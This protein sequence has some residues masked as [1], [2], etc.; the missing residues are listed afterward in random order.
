M[1]VEEPVAPFPYCASALG[2]MARRLVFDGATVRL[3]EAPQQAM[4]LK[5]VNLVFM[6]GKPGMDDVQPADRRLGNE[7]PDVSVV[8]V[9]ANH[10]LDAPTINSPKDCYSDHASDDYVQ[11]ACL[12]MFDKILHWSTRQLGNG[13]VWTILTAR[14]SIAAGDGG[15]GHTIDTNTDLKNK[16]VRM[17]GAIAKRYAGWDN[18]LGYEVMSEPRS[19]TH[20]PELSAARQAACSAIWASDPRAAC[21]VGPA[22]FYNRCNLDNLVLVRGGPAVYLA[23]FFEP[24][25][26][27]KN[28]FQGDGYPGTYDCCTVT[29]PCQKREVCGQYS[30]QCPGA[31]RVRID[32]N[33]VSAQMSFVARFRDANKAPVM[34]DQWGAQRPGDPGQAKQAEAYTRD[35][36]QAMAEASLHWTY[37]I[38]RRTTAYC[39]PRDI[40]KRELLCGDQVTH[41]EKLALLRAAMVPPPR[42][43]LPPSPPPPPP[44]P[45]TAPSPPIRVSR[46]TCS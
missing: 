43:P 3:P 18:I 27:N 6:L 40:D 1:R 28:N 29:A 12:K 5:G 45:P 46:Y 32:K 17:W 31:P 41:P 7:L 11:P 2:R 42:P 44:P 20:R 22:R 24:K 10:W 34:I 33:W 16:W 26:W 25:Y 35:V 36:T 4:V 19:D 38:W 13:T 23:N 21:V 15:D 8:R 9:V 37:W 39:G 30:Q 14:M